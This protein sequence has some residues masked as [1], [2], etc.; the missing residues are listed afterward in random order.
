[1]K[2]VHARYPHAV[3]DHQ[4]RETLAV[5]KND[6]RINVLDVFLRVGGKPA[7]GNKHALTRSLAMERANKFLKLGS[8][9]RLPPSLRLDVDDVKSESILIDDTVNTA[10]PRG[11]GHRTRF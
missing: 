9:Y 6:S 11:L 4:S 1:M 8:S 10:I 3:V 5:D 2:R 7:R